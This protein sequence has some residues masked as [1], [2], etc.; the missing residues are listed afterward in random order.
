MAYKALAMPASYPDYPNHFQV[1]A[2]FDQF[3][4]HFGL[5]EKIRFETEVVNVEPINDEWEVRVRSG[6]G[7]E[8]TTRYRAVMVANGHHW[9]PRWPEPA[10]QGSE[11]FAGEQIHVHGYR[12]PDLLKGKRVLVLGIGNS[13]ARYRCRVFA[14]R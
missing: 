3:V 10:F 13:A 8:K 12:D 11:Q 6:A 5:R 14:D 1:A 7:G 4:D 2:Y 9:D